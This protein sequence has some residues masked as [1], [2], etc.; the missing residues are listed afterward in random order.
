MSACNVAAAV[1]CPCACVLVSGLSHR[2]WAVSLGLNSWTSHIRVAAPRTLL[3]QP[4]DWRTASSLLSALFWHSHAGLSKHALG[5]PKLTGDPLHPQAVSLRA[6]VHLCTRAKVERPK[7]GSAQLRRQPKALT[8]L[9]SSWTSPVTWTF[10]LCTRLE[11][12][13]IHLA[14]VHEMKSHHPAKLQMFLSSLGS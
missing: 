3:M 8:W 5:E 2:C 1:W 14:G 9:D 4:G 13:T 11:L 6:R 12:E 10:S 7:H